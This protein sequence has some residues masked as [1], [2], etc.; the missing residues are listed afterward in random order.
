MFAVSFGGLI[1]STL[2]Q[3]GISAMPASLKTPG[4]MGFTVALW[5]VAAALIWF[6]MRM[7]SRGIL[8]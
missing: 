3:Y 5:V 8:R 2:Y 7:R 4:G 1:V 6:T